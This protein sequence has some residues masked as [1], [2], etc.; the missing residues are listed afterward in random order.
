QKTADALLMKAYGTTTIDSD[1]LNV[2]YF[3]TKNWPRLIALWKL[4]ANSPSATAQEWFG[5]ASAYYASG[6]NVNAILTVKAAAAKFPDA[7]ASAAAALAQ[8]EGKSTGQ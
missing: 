5:L 2:A 3:R 4:R 1:I 6:D 7:A 8:I